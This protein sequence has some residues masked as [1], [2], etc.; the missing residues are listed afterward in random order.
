MKFLKYISL[1]A[2]LAGCND[3]EAPDCFQSAG[4]LMSLSFPTDEFYEI[5]I[6]DEFIAI[7]QTGMEHSLTIITG[8]NLIDDIHWEV[9]DKKLTLSDGN[10]CSWV[11]DYQFPEVHI[12]MP[13][14]NQ[15]RQNGGGLIKSEGILSVENIVLVSEGRTG[16]FEL[17]LEGKEVQIA[18]NDLSNYRLSGTVDKLM[19]GFFAG[20]GRFDGSEMS[21]RE[22]SVFQ[23]GTNDMIV[24]ATEKLSGRIISNGN[25]LYTKTIPPVID[26]SQEGSGKLI[27]K[28]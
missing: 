8:E 11:R 9:A 2:L 17:A 26:V 4:E 24:H 22:V 18:N 3:P 15:I 1:I 16:D 7:L 25:V 6:N 12:T 21:A 5:E 23:R 19:V 28:E 27:Y 14:I 10:S 20:D 13:A